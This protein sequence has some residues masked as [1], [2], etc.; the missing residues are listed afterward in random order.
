MRNPH[1]EVWSQDARPDGFPDEIVF[2]LGG[3][4]AQ[5]AAVKR[6]ELD[7]MEVSAMF[8]GPLSPAASARWPRATP[9]SCT[10]TR[11]RTSR[12]CS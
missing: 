3:V 7:A 2:D 1:F 9:G 6:G 4:D 10:P 12:T 8:G 5:V 11:P